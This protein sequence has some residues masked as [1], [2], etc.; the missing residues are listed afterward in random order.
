MELQLKDLE[1]VEKKLEKVKR[2]AKTGNKE[3]QKEAGCF[4]AN[5]SAYRSRKICAQS[6]SI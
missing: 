6:R 5:K 3:A 1:T 4:R 2:T